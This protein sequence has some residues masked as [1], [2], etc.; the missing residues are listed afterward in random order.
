VCLQDAVKQ[1]GKISKLLKWPITANYLQGAE[2]ST[3]AM[4]VLHA[5]SSAKIILCLL[6]HWQ[7]CSACALSL[8]HSR[9]ANFQKFSQW[10]CLQQKCLRLS[11]WQKLFPK[12]NSSA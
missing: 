6:I 12:A 7:N 11:H 2:S 9:L 4:Y 3:K 5:E 10:P 1:A 8:F